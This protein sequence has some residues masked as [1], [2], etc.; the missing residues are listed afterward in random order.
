ME[1]YLLF[2]SWQ[3]IIQVS[4][5][6]FPNSTAVQTVSDNDRDLLRKSVRD[7]LADVSPVDKTVENASNVE[8]LAKLWPAMARQGLSTLGS[9]ESEVGLRE[10]LVVFE[11]LGRARELLSYRLAALKPVSATCVHQLDQSRRLTIRRK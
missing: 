7:F 11:E 2:A 8:A 6:N 1:G 4:Q 5:M 9:I 10:I 3:M